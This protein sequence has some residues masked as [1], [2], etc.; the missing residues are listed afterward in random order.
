MYSHCCAKTCG[1]AFSTVVGILM[2]A[3]LSA[4]G[5]HTSSTA[6]QTS[7]AYSGSVPEKLSGLYSKR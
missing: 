1:M 6:L 3:F 5:C 7:S 2:T 4:V